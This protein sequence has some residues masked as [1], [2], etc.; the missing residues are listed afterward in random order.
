MLFHVTALEYAV[1]VRRLI[2]RH[3]DFRPGG[4][5]ELKPLD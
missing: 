1:R 4:M 3:P 2:A 5:E